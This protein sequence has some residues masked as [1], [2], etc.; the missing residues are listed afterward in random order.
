[1]DS[2]DIAKVLRRIRKVVSSWK[3]PTVTQ[4]AEIRDPFRVLI[5]CILSLRTRDEV[6]ESASK[7]LFDLASNPEE[8]ISLSFSDIKKAI[9]PAAFYRVKSK[10]IVRISEELID[11]YDGIVPDSIEK[12]LELKGVGRKTANLT[13]IL[14]YGHSGICVDT[15]VHRITNRWGYVKTKNPDETEKVLRMKLPKRYWME[16]NG[17]LVTFGQNCCKPLSPHCGSCC[18]ESF[19]PRQGVV[20]SR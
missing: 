4:L 7:R 18:V 20:R 17:L 19:C 9:Y 1:M 5:S 16:I 13:V 8:M 11:R 14:G 6:T 12:L 10:R 2:K 3:T 15:H